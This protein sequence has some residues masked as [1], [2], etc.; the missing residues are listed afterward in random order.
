MLAFFARQASA[1]YHVGRSG[2]SRG[3]DRLGTQLALRSLFCEAASGYRTAS[4]PSSL[5]LSSVLWQRPHTWALPAL[6]WEFES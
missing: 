1:Q 6:P 3:Q 5:A 2:T 4:Q